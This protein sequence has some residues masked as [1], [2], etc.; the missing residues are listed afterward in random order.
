MVLFDNS[1]LRILLGPKGSISLSALPPKKWSFLY[2]TYLY[3][4]A[5][6]NSFFKSFK[7]CY[8]LSVKNIHTKEKEGGRERERDLL[9]TGMPLL[10]S[11]GPTYQWR[12]I[13][14]KHTHP[15]KGLCIRRLYISVMKYPRQLRY[16]EKRVQHWEDGSEGKALP[17]QA[18]STEFDP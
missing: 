18:W 12:K 3:K 7:L 2:S 8:S 16:W 15:L 5:A 6:I 17:E 1:K 14:R 11:P 13:K 10:N 4:H 9:R